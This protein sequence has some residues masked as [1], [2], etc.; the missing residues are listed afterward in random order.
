MD[1]KRIV[2]TGLGVISSIGIGK[3]AFKENIFKGAS[4]IKPITFFDAAA[5][6]VKVAGEISNFAPEQILGPKGLRTLDRSIKLVACGVRLALDDSRLEITE[7]NSR[8]TGISVGTT[9][10]SLS[11]ICDF[12]KEAL[13]EGVRYVNP[14]LFPNTVINSPA[15]QASIKFNIKGFNITVSTG[16]SAGLDALNYAANALRNDRARIALCGGVEEFCIQEFLGFYKAGCL[17]DSRGIVLGEGAGILV[18]EELSSAQARKAKIY[19]ELLGFGSAI[20]DL[21]K[22]MQLSLEEAGLTPEKIDYIGSAANSAEEFA[23]NEAKAIGELFGERAKGIPVSS[24][25]LLVG[26]LFSASGSLQIAAALG[27]LEKQAVPPSLLNQAQASK[28]E[29]VLINA[30][31]GTGS[32]SSLIISKFKGY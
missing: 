24:I 28:I 22:S 21:K 23:A 30:G 2:I 14:A 9:F 17:T 11:S 20:Q 4:G 10:G 13:T 32:N 15:S 6:K 31:G 26:E 16:F 27:A 1:K 19:A 8:D 5:F 25:K 18:L 7:D 29:N 3:D 12:D